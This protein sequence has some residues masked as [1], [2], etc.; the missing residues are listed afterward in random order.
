MIPLGDVAG[1]IT[2]E[3]ERANGCPPGCTACAPTAAALAATSR[4]VQPP[5]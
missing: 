1:R 2:R 4:L 5:R 3:V